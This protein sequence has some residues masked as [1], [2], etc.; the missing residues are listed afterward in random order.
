[1]TACIHPKNL[2]R[3]SFRDDP[4]LRMEDYKK[5]FTYWLQFEDARITAI[6]FAENS[7]YNLQELILIAKNKNTFSR[8]IEFLEVKESPRLPGIHYGYSDME[9]IDYAVD[10]SKLLT[11]DATIIK[12][13]GRLYFPKLKKL[14]DE[15]DKFQYNFF[16]DSRDYK[17]GKREKHYIITTLFLADV[18]FYKKY[19][20]NVK[21]QLVSGSSSH[22][23]TAYFQVL[24][25]M[26]LLKSNKINLRFSY[27]VDAV[28]IG[29][30]W[31]VNYA[32]TTYRLSSFLRLAFRKVLPGFKI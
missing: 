19:L 11:E 22:M 14:L 9:I 24:K 7:G 5:A 29:A 27:N 28:G 16:A 26:S 6:V 23:E 18:S 12:T 13:T 25:P 2:N 8:K 32:S 20:F 21:Q 17:I 4:V 31:N 15:Q 1:M 30:H 3:S 10:N